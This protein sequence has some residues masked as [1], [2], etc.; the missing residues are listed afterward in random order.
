MIHLTVHLVR[1]IELYEPEYMR[2]MYPFVRLMKI[3]KGHVRIQN[4][5][6]GC[7]IETYIAKKALEIC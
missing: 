6:E 3:L 4:H 1:E 7:I 5:P 2:W